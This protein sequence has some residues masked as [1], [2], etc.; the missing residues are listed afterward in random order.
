MDYMKLNKVTRKS[1]LPIPFIHQ[2]LD[3]LDGKEFYCFHDGYLGYN[4]IVIAPKDQERQNS[5]APIE[6]LH[7]EGFHLDYA[8]LIQCFKDA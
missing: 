4:H 8:M 6:S 2:M 1:H 7:L 3:R 5:H